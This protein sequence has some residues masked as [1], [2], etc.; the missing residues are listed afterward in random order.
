MHY[1]YICSIPKHKSHHTH[2]QYIRSFS[3]NKGQHVSLK[4]NSNFH[5]K[6]TSPIKEFD[7]DIKSALTFLEVLHPRFADDY[8]SWIQVGMALKS[9]NPILL[10]AWD[11]WSQLSPKYKPGE[12]DYKWQSFRRTG[13][14]IYTLAKYASVS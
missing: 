11:K 6:Q 10:K 1:K 2:H 8:W 14:T 12:C 4:Q 13:I 5:P 7:T 3:Q 9:V